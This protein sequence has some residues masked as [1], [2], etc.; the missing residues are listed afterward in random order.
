MSGVAG[1][2]RTFLAE[3]LCLAWGT[4]AESLSKVFCAEDALY[5]LIR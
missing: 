1:L 4:W 5:E 2:S 3:K